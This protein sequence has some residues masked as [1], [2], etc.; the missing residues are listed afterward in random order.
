M[1][2]RIAAW[3]IHDLESVE[4]LVHVRPNYEKH[5]ESWITQDP[6]IISDDLLLIGRQRQTRFGTIVDL[7]GLNSHGDIVMVE[8][9]RNKTSR[10]M[11]AQALEYAAWASSLSYQE[12]IEIA[13]EFLGSEDALE[14]AFREKFGVELPDTLNQAQQI[15]LV[16]MSIKESTAAVVEYLAENYGVAINAIGLSMV[17]VN[18]S[19][20][21]LRDAVIEHDES[22]PPATRK[23]AKKTTSEELLN[24][25]HDVGNGELADYFWSIRDRF[26][27]VETLT[28]CWNF[29]ASGA[30]SNRVV[31][32]VFPFGT[33][34]ARSEVGSRFVISLMPESL[35]DAYG[36]TA[37]ECVAFINQCQTEYGQ[38]VP[39][40]KTGKQRFAVDTLQNGHA[41]FANFCE[42]FGIEN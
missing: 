13:D 1:A 39:A 11:I 28:W 35:A 7:M 36:K 20:I 41:F 26:K 34:H 42:F 27:S 24:K 30:K 14:E 12:V 10:E 37:A 17:E 38:T 19:K 40:P 16:A 5:L 23:R 31:M 22:T 32:T 9:K 3:K 8:L 21:L 18:G 29:R 25:G 2:R 4:K 33:K 6:S 15:V